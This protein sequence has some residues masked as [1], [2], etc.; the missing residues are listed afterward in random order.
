MGFAPELGEAWS[1]LA[2][3]LLS[4]V[5]AATAVD[6]EGT[7][8][9]LA[10][11]DRG[12]WDQECIDEAHE[13]LRRGR[14][15]R[16]TTPLQLEAEISAHHTF[17]RTADAVDWV[18]IRDL[19]HQLLDV[20]GENAG[21]QLNM[22]VAIAEAGDL[23]AAMGLL[24][25]L[26]Q[27]AVGEPWRVHA[28]RAHIHQLATDSQAAR[29]QWQLAAQTAPPTLIAQLQHRAEQQQLQ[30]NGDESSPEVIEDGSGIPAE[31]SPDPTTDIQ[32]R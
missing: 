13:A 12:Q 14:R 15:L 18:A 8:V 29:H 27:T 25:Q 21:I 32:S 20:G 31:G 9:P 2:L 17:A 16:L 1:L 26:E 6:S 3:L 11:Q 19:Y 23:A 30:A 24:D 22:A 7:F 28:A 4:E 5:R 10:D